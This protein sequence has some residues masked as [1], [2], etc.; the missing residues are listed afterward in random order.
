MFEK[1]LQAFRSGD[2]PYADVRSDLKRLLAAGAPAQELREVL[3]RWESTEPLPGYAHEEVVQL[4]D[5]AKIPARDTGSNPAPSEHSDPE[6]IEAGGNQAAVAPPVLRAGV[7]AAD[8]AALRAALETEHRTTRD[9]S[10]ALAA[11]IA[12]EAAARARSD[13][14]LREAEHV[15]AE[16]ESVRDSL[17]TRDAAIAQL[18][19]LLSERNAELAE[20]QSEHIS[21]APERTS[22]APERTSMASERDATLAQLKHS[23]D[24]RDTQLAALQHEHARIVP[25][26]EARAASAE[27][28][29][30]AAQTRIDAL[31]TEL[32]ASRD[33]AAALKAQCDG[34]ESRLA[35]AHE[36][37]SAAQ[38]QAVA[39]LE[40]LQSSEWRRGSQHSEDAAPAARHPPAK[41]RGRFRRG[42]IAAMGAGA[43]ILVIAVIAWALHWASAPPQELTISKPLPAPGTVI[44]DC[45]TCPVMT[46][47]PAGRFKQGS[48]LAENGVASFE[49]PLHWVAI[50]RAFAMS[51]NAVTVDEFRAFI[52]ATGRGMQGCETYDGE[53]RLRPDSSWENPGFVQTGSHPVTCVSWNDAKAYADWLST[54]T[55]HRYRLPS[56]SEW[57]YAARAGGEAVQPWNPDGSGA[58]ASANV[59]DESAARRFP[60]WTIF[61]CDDRYVYTAPVGSFNANAFGLN[62]ML[63]NVF[64]WTQDCWHADYTGAPIDG[65]ARMDGD[66]T[67][68][69]LRGGSWFSTPAYVRANYRNH[70]GAD[71]RTSTVGIR[72]V[73]DIVS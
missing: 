2:L 52:A 70:F 29:L 27:D 64:Q 22:T 57:E 10:R 39:Y 51:T 36:E 21:T 46:V 50:G 48:P 69:E 25:G 63:G 24:M 72:L 68:R 16:L 32:Q 4:L 18:H 31:T 6:Q 34:A 73:R 56:A 42:V 30:R 60:G 33:A 65:S 15:H 54:S 23:L 5:A 53:W 1:V 26:L 9:L 44:I 20:L 45:P 61:A 71:Y 37:L 17:R 47:L 38:A 62:D 55:G 49:T 67:E 8:L 7:P 3:R 13:E 59:A 41:G 12:S 28:A 35:S 14:A 40:S 58:C 66:C 19:R 43:A 11:R